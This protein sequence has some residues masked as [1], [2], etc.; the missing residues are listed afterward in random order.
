MRFYLAAVLLAAAALVRAGHDE[1]VSVDGYRVAFVALP[2]EMIRPPSHGGARAGTDSHHV[3]VVIVEE[4]SGRALAGAKVAA[5]VRDAGVPG[6]MK[7][8]APMSIGAAPAY[9]NF[10][11]L[12][13]AGPYRIEMEFQAPGG[14]GVRTAAFD[15]EHPGRR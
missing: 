2:A 6:P 15:Y 14:D 13:G 11:P 4:A 10:F 9:G 5:R 7:P 8:L 12:H 3:I 1:P